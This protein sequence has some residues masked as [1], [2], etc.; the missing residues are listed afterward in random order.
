MYF[1]HGLLGKADPDLG[2]LYCEFGVFKG[3]SINFIA[4]ETSHTIHGFDSFEGLPEEWTPGFPK[5]AFELEQI[6]E[7]R[8]NVVLHKGWFEDTLPV[9][10][11]KYEG[12]I[13]F[14]HFDAD[15]YSSTKTVFDQLGER[16]VP[17]TIL[18]FDEF[19]NYPAWQYGE[20]RA[21]ME[22]VES[23][24]V[25]FEYLGYCSGTGQQVSVRI[26]RIGKTRH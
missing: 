13:E 24:Q 18:Q 25:E 2:G 6:P 16:I 11:K 9:F 23:Y 12:P 22:F 26:V 15:L 4:S 10:T 5:A 20:Y 3:E 8:R 21:F 7:V 19:F 17:G 1:Y 14:G